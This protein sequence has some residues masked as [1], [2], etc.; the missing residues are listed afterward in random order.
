[1]YVQVRLAR[2]GA[3]CAE[4]YIILHLTL[5]VKTFLQIILKT[6][7]PKLLTIKY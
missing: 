1:M 3:P 2:G 5:F 6:F 4:I 7:I